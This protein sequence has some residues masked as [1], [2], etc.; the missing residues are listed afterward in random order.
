MAGEDRREQIL[1]AAERVATV[2]G[3]EALTMRS[4]AAAAGVSLRLVQYYFHS[5]AGLLDAVLTRFSERGYADSR[6]RIDAIADTSAARRLQMFARSVLPTDDEGRRFHRLGVSFA[7]LAIREP[8]LAQTAYRANLAVL[9][10]VL[11]G[12]IGDAA[13]ESGSDRIDAVAEARLLMSALH[14]LATMT[15][16]GQIDEIE[17]ADLVDRLLLGRTWFDATVGSQPSE[18]S[19]A[20]ANNPDSVCSIKPSVSSESRARSR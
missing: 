11:A 18:P 1:A 8:D 17:A 6:S 2:D 16:V 3:L 10:S 19:P 5:K 7:S 4:A 9:E 14:G 15:M 12:M 13:A 20:R